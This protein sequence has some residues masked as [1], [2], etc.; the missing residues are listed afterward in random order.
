ME[1][2]QKDQDDLT[3]LMDRKMIELDKKLYQE[4]QQKE[5]DRD[6]MARRQRQEMLEQEL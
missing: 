2:R 6:N 5:I 3:K 1:Q 4:V